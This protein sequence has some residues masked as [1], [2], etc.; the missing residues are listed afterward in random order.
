MDTT[1]LALDR[2]PLFLLLLTGIQLSAYA[3]MAGLKWWWLGRLGVVDSDRRRIF[4]SRR[5]GFD[6]ASLLAAYPE[7]RLRM[8]DSFCRKGHHV[9]TGL[10]YLF[11]VEEVIAEPRLMVITILIQGSLNL[12]MLLVAYR[13]DRVWGLGG[14]LFGGVARIRDGQLARANLVVANISLLAQYLACAGIAL[15]FLQ[16]MVGDALFVELVSFVY[17]PMVVGDAAGEIIGGTWGRQTIRVR[18]IGEINKKSWLGVMAVCIGSFVAVLA[19]I[20][21]AGLPRGLIGLAAVVAMTTTV[22]ELVAPRSTDN[23]MIPLS[24]LLCVLAW[25]RLA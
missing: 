19:H 7:R 23:F 2:V 4:S 18:G 12:A 6:L 9:Y 13:S 15:I 16:P 21:S 11:V 22:V 14:W 25:F 24:N 1:P 8:I 17:L 5:E 10:L 3:L 20:H